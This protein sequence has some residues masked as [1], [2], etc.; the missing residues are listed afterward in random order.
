MSREALSRGGVGVGTRFSLLSVTSIEHVHG[1][2][3]HGLKEV[4]A[5]FEHK[6]S[7]QRESL[8]QLYSIV[9]YSGASL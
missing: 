5:H 2:E 7:K 4:L 8:F 6:V 9:S 3:T 1:G